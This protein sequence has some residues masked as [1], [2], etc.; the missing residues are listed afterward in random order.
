M[1]GKFGENL[2]ILK[3]FWEICYGTLGS[4]FRKFHLS[5]DK[6]F[7]EIIFQKIIKFEIKIWKFN[8]NLKEML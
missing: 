2:K 5:R 7:V 3:K 4:T 6:N 1:A 8:E